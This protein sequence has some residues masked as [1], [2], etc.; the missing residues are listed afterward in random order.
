[1]KQLKFGNAVLCEFVARGEG[2]KVTLVNAFP[3][4]VL[5]AHMPA[6]LHLGLYVELLLGND[7]PIEVDI[8]FLL[9]D[10]KIGSGKAQIA[11]SLGGVP[12]IFAIPAMEISVDRDSTLKVVATCMGYRKTDLLSKHIKVQPQ[13][14]A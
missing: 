13:P 9:D 6:Q 7:E 1:M 3:G 14:S 8:E 10:E 4:E 11:K 5:V 12:A 2:N